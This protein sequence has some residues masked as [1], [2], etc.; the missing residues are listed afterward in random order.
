MSMASTTLTERIVDDF[1]AL[2]TKLTQNRKGYQL[3]K[4]EIQRYDR[5]IHGTGNAHMLRKDD[6]LGKDN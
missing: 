1:S 6:F 4:L 5:N 3:S 2:T